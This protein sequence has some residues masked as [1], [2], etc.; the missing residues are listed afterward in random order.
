MGERQFH[1]H[2]EHP[3]LCA[4][5]PRVSSH[6]LSELVTIRLKLDDRS[7]TSRS[8]NLLRFDRS[9]VVR[10]S[11]TCGSRVLAVPSLIGP[12]ERHIF[13][14]TAGYACLL[15]RGHTSRRDY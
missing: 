14:V 1:F 3:P 13:N 9:G 11:I 10:P 4:L 8:A 15:T 2:S 6:R 12:N 7:E 5:H